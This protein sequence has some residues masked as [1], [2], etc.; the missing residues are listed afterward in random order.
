MNRHVQQISNV[1]GSQ[2]HHNLMLLLTQKRKLKLVLKLQLSLPHKRL[3]LMQQLLFKA[4]LLALVQMLDSL[5]I[6]VA[7]SRS[8]LKLLPKAVIQN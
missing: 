1:I 8:K 5:K 6:E 2:W 4:H 7:D 3:L